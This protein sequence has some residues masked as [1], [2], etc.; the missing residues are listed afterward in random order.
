MRKI[1]NIQGLLAE[2]QLLYAEENT[3]KDKVCIGNMLP[4]K[5]SLETLKEYVRQNFGSAELIDYDA[6]D[7]QDEYMHL[8]QAELVNEYSIRSIDLWR[9]LSNRLIFKVLQSG[10]LQHSVM[11]KQQ[12]LI[13][14]RSAMNLKLKQDQSI[15]DARQQ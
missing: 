15:L 2:K 1:E 13:A 8:S 4:L 11:R 12:L 3:Q 10:N 7:Q 5:T 14:F 6:I 9:E